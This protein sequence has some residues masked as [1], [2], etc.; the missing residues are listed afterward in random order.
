MPVCSNRGC[1]ERSLYMSPRVRQDLS[2]NKCF[3]NFMTVL[4]SGQWKRQTKNFGKEM[5]AF[6]EIKTLQIAL[7]L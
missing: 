2:I 7:M 4:S 6:V 5:P 3:A 1:I